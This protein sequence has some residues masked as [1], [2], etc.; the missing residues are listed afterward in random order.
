[1]KAFGVALKH[2]GF[3]NIVAHS[4]LAINSKNLGH[5]ISLD[6]LKAHVNESAGIARDLLEMQVDYPENPAWWLT[7]DW[8]G[9]GPL[10]HR[11]VPWPARHSLSS[12]V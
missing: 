12:A 10:R 8:N 5:L 3:R 7:V 11:Q 4:P 9:R 2:A 6:E 1:M